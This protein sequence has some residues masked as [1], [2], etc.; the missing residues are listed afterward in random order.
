M[1][2]SEHINQTRLKE[3]VYSLAGMKTKMENFIFRQ[4]LVKNY[5]IEISN[6]EN[7]LLLQIMPCLLNIRLPR[8][9][10]SSGTQ[11]LS[12]NGLPLQKYSTFRLASLREK[13]IVPS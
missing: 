7:N 4:R 12:I 11:F 6:T 8:L 13:E 3:T 1:P 2:I 9:N 10:K 5:T